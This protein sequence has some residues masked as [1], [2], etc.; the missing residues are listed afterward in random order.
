MFTLQE[1]IVLRSSLEHIQILGKD[2]KAIAALQT[3]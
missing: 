3:N 2:A 1:L